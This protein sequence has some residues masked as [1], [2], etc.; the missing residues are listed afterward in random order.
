MSVDMSFTDFVIAICRKYGI[1]S[2]KVDYSGEGDSGWIEPP[3]AS[4]EDENKK[5]TKELI[6]A[7]DKDVE[8]ILS[9]IDK[10]SE[11]F[12][13]LLEDEDDLE[14]A[15][16]Y[17]KNTRRSDD[18][19]CLFL[20][21]V[22]FFADHYLENNH[23]GWEINEGMSGYFCWSVEDESGEFFSRVPVIEYDEQTNSI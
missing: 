4:F 20:K 5:L 12:K 19:Q 23:G 13:F 8:K 6:E 15:I 17:V 2:V 22:A 9:A 18:S 7:I 14:S 16:E 10:E 1:K 11:Q 3:E 21:L